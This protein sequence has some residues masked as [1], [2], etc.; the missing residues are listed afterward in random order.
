MRTQS[1]TWSDYKKNNTVKFL[2]GITPH[3]HISF[4]SSAWGGRISDRHI[5]QSS[6]FLDLLYP[7]DEVMADRGFTI[8]EDLLLRHDK[9][10]IPPFSK[11]RQQMYT[12]DVE[13]MK[14]VAN[15]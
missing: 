6:R 7:G 13:L 5:V 4:I 9:L 2:V 8:E 1:L 3:G 15:L 11:N 10:T 12:A 14:H